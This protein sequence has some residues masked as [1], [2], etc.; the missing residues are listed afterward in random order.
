[1]FGDLAARPIDSSIF[2]IED[3]VVVKF[4]EILF[5]L[6]SFL[7]LQLSLL[8]KLQ[9]LLDDLLLRLVE[10]WPVDLEVFID[11]FYFVKMGGF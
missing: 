1:M 6:D 7:G 11:H 4:N 3:R 5:P 9:L 8:L 2:L 10:E